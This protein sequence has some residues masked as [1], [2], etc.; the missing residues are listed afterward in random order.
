MWEPG[1]RCETDP[2]CL[3]V[4]AGEQTMGLA[5]AQSVHWNSQSR[6]RSFAFANKRR[7]SS[8]GELWHTDCFFKDKK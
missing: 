8:L 1:G 2:V 7:H 3:Q 5:D 6:R 4:A